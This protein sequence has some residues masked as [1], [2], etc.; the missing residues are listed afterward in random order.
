MNRFGTAVL[1]LLL[2]H[3]AI[4]LAEGD[5]LEAIEKDLSSIIKEMDAM[6]SELD[7]IQDLAAAPKATAIRVEIV[8]GA[9]FPAP[10]SGRLSIGGKTENERDWTKSER[11]AFSGGAPLGFQAPLLPGTYSA[12]FEIVHPSWT[13]APSADF[14]AI[15]KKGETFVLKLNVSPIPGKS[16][17]VLA[18]VREK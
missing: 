3:P 11:D 6:S 2:L 14:Q 16:E 8:G 7:R 10:F 5:S 13:V 4:L 9:G 12:R 15:L 1:L 18:P 17:P